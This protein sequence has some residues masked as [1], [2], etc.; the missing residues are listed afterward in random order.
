MSP[1][2]PLGSA[3]AEPQSQSNRPRP[4]QPNALYYA[5]T[6][7]LEGSGDVS[8]SVTEVVTTWCSDGH[9]HAESFPLASGPASGGYNIARAE[10][11]G[12]DTGNA[13]QAE[14][15]AGC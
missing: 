2:S 9:K 6:A 13:T 15:D 14:S 4:G 1:D 8:D 5:V 10:Y 3:S 11:A 7:Q 12:G